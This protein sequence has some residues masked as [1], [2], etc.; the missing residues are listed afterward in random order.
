MRE[1]GVGRREEGE[2]G[3]R[4]RK[5][6][7]GGR[8]LKMLQK[9]TSGDGLFYCLGWVHVLQVIPGPHISGGG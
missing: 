4:E 8:G 6:G 7:K 3:G 9:T 1:E 2:R 5:G